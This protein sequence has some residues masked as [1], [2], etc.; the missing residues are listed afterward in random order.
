MRTSATCVHFTDV[1]PKAQK[2][3][4]LPMLGVGS[5]GLNLFLQIQ[6][7]LLIVSGIRLRPPVKEE[8]RKIW[9]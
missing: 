6:R 8:L 1:E 2:L 3:N 9:H 4:K 7:L 5:Q